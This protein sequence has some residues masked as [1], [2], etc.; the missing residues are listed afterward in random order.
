M[1]RSWLEA[2]ARDF[3]SQAPSCRT[4]RTIAIVRL[5]RG[6]QSYGH[7]HS[8]DAREF[9]SKDIALPRFETGH[10][11][12]HRAIIIDPDQS[13]DLLFALTHIVSEKVPGDGSKA[14]SPRFICAV[15]RGL[16]YRGRSPCPEPSSTP[17]SADRIAA[18][19]DGYKLRRRSESMLRTRG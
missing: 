12:I 3:L 16:D 2:H 4:R 18:G 11:H 7:G 1:S 6:P 17:R 15:Y 19:R 5:P 9:G 10:R 14:R 8:E 13:F